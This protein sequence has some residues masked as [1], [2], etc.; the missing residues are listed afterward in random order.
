MGFVMRL[1]PA[2]LL[3][4]GFLVS[5]CGLSPALHHHSAD[6][7]K[8]ES[9]TEAPVAACPFSFP[10][11]GLCASW[12]WTEHPVSEVTVS[13]EVKFWSATDG[14]ADGPYVTPS[15]SLR[16]FLWMPSMGHGSSPIEVTSVSTGIYQ[17][18]EIYFTMP[19]DWTLNLQLKNGNQVIEAANIPISISGSKGTP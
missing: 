6:D 11:A 15:Y 18:K 4:I 10:K 1:L 9:S 8:K 16:P 19:G 7:A 5:S 2:A 13:A 3:P 17:L 12:T 14:T